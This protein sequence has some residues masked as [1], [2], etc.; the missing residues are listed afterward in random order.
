MLKK[1]GAN[2]YAIKRV[3]Q[4]IGLL[5]YKKIIF[6]SDNEPALLALKQAVKAERSEEIIMEE[7]KGTAVTVV[8]HANGELERMGKEPID[9]FN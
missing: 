6:K 3:G 1:K 8:G 2:A 9:I 7:A 4:D 5:G